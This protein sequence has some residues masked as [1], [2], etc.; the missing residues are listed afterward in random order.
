[1]VAGARARTLCLLAGFAICAGAPGLARSDPALYTGS[2]HLRLWERP[3]P[4]GASL[5]GPGL[6]NPAS[7]N[8][9]SLSGNG[10]AGF[11][12]PRDFSFRAG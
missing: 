9:L 11:T 3:V 12:L 1:M 6:S 4:Y 8:P 2:V 7:G 5:S 10:P